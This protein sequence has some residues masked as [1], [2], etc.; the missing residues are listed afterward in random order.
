MHLPNLTD[1]ELIA[2]VRT[3][4]DLVTSDLERELADRLA[5]A[6]DE[7]ERLNTEL[8]NQD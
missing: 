2:F 1:E 8:Q 3:Q 4:L 7:I 5:A 6:L